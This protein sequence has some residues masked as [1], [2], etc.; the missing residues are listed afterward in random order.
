MCEEA[1]LGPDLKLLEG[2]ARR[3]SLNNTMMAGSSTS[4]SRCRHPCHL[5]VKIHPQKVALVL[6]VFPWFSCSHRMISKAH[7]SHVRGSNKTALLKTAAHNF[8]CWYPGSVQKLVFTLGC[9]CYMERSSVCPFAKDWRKQGCSKSAT[10][11]PKKSE[12]NKNK[13]QFEK[14]V[15]FRRDRCVCRSN[16]SSQ[17]FSSSGS[18][19]ATS[20]D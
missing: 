4:F 9:N 6:S 12:Q 5:K 17:L 3:D 18:L 10:L 13:E 7:R 14:S 11:W 1:R 16:C 2:K 20:T 8:F 15:G 19:P